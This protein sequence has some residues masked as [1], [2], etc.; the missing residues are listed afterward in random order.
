M[1]VIEKFPKRLKEKREELGLTQARLAEIINV[2][3]QTISSYE[4]NT[5]G[6]GKTPSLENAVALAEN[7]NVSLDWLCGSDERTKVCL[8]TLKDVVLYLQ[9]LTNYIECHVGSV[10][11]PIPDEFQ[12]AEYDE[13]GHEYYETQYK[14]AQ[15]VL[16]NKT[17]GDFFRNRNKVYTL[18]LDGIVP[19]DFYDS[20]YLGELSKL[21]KH[22]VGLKGGANLGDFSSEEAP[23]CPTSNE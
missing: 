3:T 13:D 4:R 15:F 19:K 7:L 1:L 11:L 6:K 12:V 22:S 20:W 17:L 21:A 10:L 9:E 16:K 5:S 23:P 18:Y 2:S 14:A 8:G